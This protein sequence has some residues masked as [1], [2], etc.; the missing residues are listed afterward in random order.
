MCCRRPRVP[1]L[2]G[3]RGGPGRWSYDALE[4]RAPAGPWRADAL[5]PA[6]VLATTTVAVSVALSRESIRVRWR[7]RLIGTLADQWLAGT[8]FYRP[9]QG[10]RASNPAYRVADDV[11]MAIDLL[12]DFALGLRDASISASTLVGILRDVGGGIALADLWLP[13]SM[14]VAPLL[15]GTLASAATL[16][17]GRSLPSRVAEKNEAEARFF[18]ALARLHENAEPVALQGGAAE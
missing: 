18:C 15:Y 10:E 6:I 14:V 8:R 5:F 9:T 1:L 16:R 17:I 7:A 13:A 4:A 11:R 12:V 3:C 2:V